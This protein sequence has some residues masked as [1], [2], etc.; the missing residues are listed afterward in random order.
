MK[1]VLPVLV[2]VSLVAIVPPALGGDTDSPHCV[3]IT[4]AMKP[5][6]LHLQSKGEAL[7]QVSGDGCAAG[8][9]IIQSARLDGGI[10][11]EHQPSHGKNLL[12]RADR[13]GL[14]HFLGSM[15]PARWV[16][17]IHLGFEILRADGVTLRTTV[18]LQVVDTD[19]EL[20]FSDRDTAALG[21]TFHL[22]GRNLQGPRL[23]V[24][25]TDKA[26]GT[27]VR[28]PVVVSPV[29]GSYPG[30]GNVDVLRVLVPS[31][32][33]TGDVTVTVRQQTSNPIAFTVAT[34]SGGGGTKGPPR[35]FILLPSSGSVAMPVAITGMNFDRNAIVWF[36]TTP[37]ITIVS[38]NTPNLP[39]IGQVS[40]IVTL[41]PFGAQSGPLVIEDQGGRRSNGFPFVVR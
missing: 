31:G 9:F 32:A 18:F 39:L 22:V 38:F 24:D 8:D 25:L 26:R 30:I 7:V 17:G 19:P 10:A 36:G 21:E 11:L 37:S 23:R 35:I 5:G 33:T 16:G 28:L 14:V 40:E 34:G 27:A 15:S 4:A 1:R 6:V 20:L 13:P 29:Q 3:E 2:F 12:L 41:V